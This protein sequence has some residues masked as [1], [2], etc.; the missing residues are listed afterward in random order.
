MVIFDDNH[1]SVLNLFSHDR[2]VWLRKYQSR[3]VFFWR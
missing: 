1:L 2:V 3:V